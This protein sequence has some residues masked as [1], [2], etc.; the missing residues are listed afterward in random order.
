MNIALLGIALKNTDEIELLW[1]RLSWYTSAFF[2]YN[3]NLP[4]HN[5][6]LGSAPPKNTHKRV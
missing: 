2:N 5:H 1:R 4:A 3:S 6:E